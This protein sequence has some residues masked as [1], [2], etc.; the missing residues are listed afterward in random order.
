MSD[1]APDEPRRPGCL[2][3]AVLFGALIAVLLVIESR[4]PDEHS[5]TP[6]ESGPSQALCTPANEEAGTPMV[7][8]VDRTAREVFVNPA[9][10]STTAFD[11][12]TGWAKWAANCLVGQKRA[13]IR[14]GYTGKELATWSDAFG[15][16]SEE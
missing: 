15:Y 10:W 1:P 8:K 3:P 5:A 13:T 16:S 4:K 9:L 7:M 14:H 12:R 2:F 11:A 6:R